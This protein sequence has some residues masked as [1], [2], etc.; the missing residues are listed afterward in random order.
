[1]FR[2]MRKKTKNIFNWKRK[3]KII[4]FLAAPVSFMLLIPLDL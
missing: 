4:F 2:N 1:M 3:S